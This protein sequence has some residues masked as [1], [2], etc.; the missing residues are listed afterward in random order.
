MS[1][2]ESPEW[3][4]RLQVKHCNLARIICCSKDRALA[5]YCNAI[6]FL[7]VEG[8]LPATSLLAALQPTYKAFSESEVFCRAQK[9][10]NSFALLNFFYFNTRSLSLRSR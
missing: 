7:S 1:T 5:V 2:L 8:V 10:E 4:P 3:R 9:I 6:D